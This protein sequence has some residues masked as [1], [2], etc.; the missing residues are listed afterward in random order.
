MLVILIIGAVIAYL[1]ISGIVKGKSKL[2][3]GRVQRS[4]RELQSAPHDLRPTWFYDNE[5]QK[6]FAI[7][8]ENLLNKSSIPEEFRQHVYS[9]KDG[10]TM[11]ANFLALM[12]QKGATFNE[13]I[14]GAADLIADTWKFQQSKNT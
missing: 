14:L 11:I 8:F 2:H 9:D 6:D 7:L 4:L 10:A 1:V 13:Q 5:K 3:Y 12:E